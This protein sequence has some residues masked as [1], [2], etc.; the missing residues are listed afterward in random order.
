MMANL[1]RE[2]RE[3]GCP[4]R[5]GDPRARVWLEQKRYAA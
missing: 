1:D 4:Y 3:L 2:L 5:S